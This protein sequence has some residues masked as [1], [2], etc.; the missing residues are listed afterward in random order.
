[1][2][3][4]L[5]LSFSLLVL[6][7]SEVLSLLRLPQDSLRDAGIALLVLVGLGYLIPPLGALLERPFARVGTRRPSG[8]GRRVRARPGPRRAVRAVRRADPGGHHRDRGDPPGRADRG[9]PH[10]RVRRRDRGAAARGRG[11]R[12]ASSRAGSARSAGTRPWCARSAGSSSSSWPWPS[13]STPSPGCS[14]TCPATP[15]ALQG[16]GA[17]SASSSTRSPASRT[18][19]LAK[20][21]PNATTLVNCG[22][23][24]NFTGITTWL[25]TPGGKPLSLRA[26]R[27]KVVLVDFWTYSCINCQRTLP[28]VEAWYQRVRQGRARGGRRAHPGVRVRARRLQR[29][30]AGGRASASRYPV[31]IDDNYATWNAY[32]NEYWPADYLIDATGHVRHVHFGEGDYA[33]PRADPPAAHRR[34]SRAGASPR[35]PT[36]RTRPRP[37]S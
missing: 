2:I 20:C 23:A 24:P 16:I 28:H 10:R 3:V 25:N 6:A 27:G 9:H 17:R 1:M 18:P 32:N 22:P 14:A 34:P 11:G 15:T 12:A 36:C 4:G 21:N 37:A 8:T 31:A 13:R 26:L 35:R 30:G 7:G 29:A 5:V 33:A 19:S